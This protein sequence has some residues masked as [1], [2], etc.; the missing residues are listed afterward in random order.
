M[1]AKR[2]QSVPD[3]FL[4]TVAFIFRRLSYGDYPNFIPLIVFCEDD[5]GHDSLQK[6]DTPHL[7]SP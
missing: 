2:S 5:N 6:S 4:E 1:V 7:C 3:F